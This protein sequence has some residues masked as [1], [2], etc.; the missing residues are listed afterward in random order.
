MGLYAVTDSHS[1]NSEDWIKR[2]TWDLPTQIDAFLDAIH[3]PGIP[4]GLVE[5]VR[6]FM[7]LPA[8]RR[9]PQSL[10]RQLFLEG[11]LTKEGKPITK[12]E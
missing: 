1:V 6:L 10:R 7:A 5:S 11:L 2:G 12:Y 9:M 8:A 4:G 3:R